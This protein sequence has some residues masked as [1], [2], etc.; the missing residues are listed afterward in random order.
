MNNKTNIIVTLL[1][2]ASCAFVS[3][4]DWT[5][6]ESIGIKQPGIEEQNPELYT[7]YLENLRQYKADTEHKKVYAWFDNS[8]KNP[9]SRA[10]H[11]TS[12]PDSID[13]VGLMYPSELATFEKEEIVTLQ[14]KGTKV[15][16][17][18]SYDEIK[19]QYE[20]LISTQPEL[21]NESTF[22]AFLKKEVEKQLAYAEPFDGIIIK[23]VGQNPKYMNEEDKAIYTEMQNIFLNAMLTWKSQNSNKILSFEGKPQNLVDKNILNNFLHIIIDAFQVS[24]ETELN[25]SILECL[26]TNVPTDR[27]I[28][29][30]SSPSSDGT[31]GFWGTTEAIIESAYWTTAESNIYTKAGIA[32]NNVQYDYYRTNGTYRT[33]RETINIMNPAP[34]K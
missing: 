11:I 24:N 32:I 26:E 16:Y 17:T 33:V 20:D 13:I 14:Q 8:K 31:E 19:A 27:F 10:Q 9:T 34:V 1:F 29:A 5:D 23:Y 3:C 15:V 28:I 7:K 21:E 2:A 22:D 25:L 18:I 30:V 12:L 6:V 4:D